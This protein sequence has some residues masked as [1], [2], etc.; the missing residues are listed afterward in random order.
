MNERIG[1][2]RDLPRQGGLAGRF[3]MGHRFARQPA[4]IEFAANAIRAFE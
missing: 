4:A 3:G 2:G 1:L